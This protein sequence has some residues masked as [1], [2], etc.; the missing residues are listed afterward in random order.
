VSAEVREIAS[1]A[2][3]DAAL[4]LA[5]AAGRSDPG[6]APPELGAMRLLLSRKSAYCRHAAVRPLLAFED[7][8][9]VATVTA[10]ADPRNAAAGGERVGTL[11]LFEAAPGAERAVGA[12]L[13][14]ACTGLAAWGATSVL[15]PQ[16][17]HQNYGF[18]LLV[19]DR[20]GRPLDG[21]AYQ[22]PYYRRY[23]EAA[24]FREVH[25]YAAFSIALAHPDVQSRIAAALAELPRGTR[26][27]PASRWRYRAAVARFADLHSRA[28]VGVW[29]DTPV[30]VDEAWEQMRH[31]RLAIPPGF[32]LF[33]E[34]DG[35]PVGFV[36]CL[37]DHAE[38]RNGRR[39]ERPGLGAALGAL[40]RRRCIR[41]AGVYA[42]GVVPGVRRRGL[43]AGLVA[44]A[45]DAMRRRGFYEAVYA[46]VLDDNL[47]SRALARRFAGQPSW[48]WAM[49]ERRPA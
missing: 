8:R 16:N 30:F 35:E 4:A 49:Y 28:F 45:L 5:R 14:D 42:I 9:P 3:V 37:P 19:D 18:G 11:G 31:A 13:A 7:G 6:W 15:A 2:D 33:A 21:L 38:V 25:R 39:A 12:L 41:R 22:P 40:V 23:L 43:G 32:F 47:P 17:G 24:R 29:G 34:L 10:F 36:L 46:L 26:L 1:R 20:G 27:V 44:A 48:N